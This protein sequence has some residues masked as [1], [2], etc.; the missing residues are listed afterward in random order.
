[1]HE[2]PK[3]AH[4]HIVTGAVVL[5]RIVPARKNHVQ[6]VEDLNTTGSWVMEE[7]EDKE[8]MRNAL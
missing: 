6:K 8:L 7:N 5:I 2:N 4:T 1:M 3:R